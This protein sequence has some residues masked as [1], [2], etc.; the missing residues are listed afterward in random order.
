MPSKRVSGF[1][2]AFDD[3]L[4][5]NRR[6]LDTL[7]GG[8]DLGRSP[9]GDGSQSV[10]TTPRPSDRAEAYS[11]PARTPAERA[12]DEKLGPRW[13]YDVM[14]RIRENGEL[15]VR[16]RVTVPGRGV[17]RNPVWNR[18]RGVM[19]RYMRSVRQK[20]KRFSRRLRPA[21]SYFEI[22]GVLS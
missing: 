10:S 21:R 4:E 14:E 22:L 19:D 1:S 16:C 18:G 6:E 3:M 2:S 9:A 12:L 7:S 17:T 13:R 15:V 20:V 8:G 5:R 11:P